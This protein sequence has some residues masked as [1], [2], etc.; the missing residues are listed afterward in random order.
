MIS[1]LPAA[2]R[3]VIHHTSDTAEMVAMG[4]RNDH[5]HDR[6]F[7][8][9]LI[10]EVERGPRRFFDGQRVNHD[11]AGIALDERD[12]REVEAAHLV[13]ARDDLKQSRTPC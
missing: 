10:D 8:E 7:A 2:K 12:V 5:R 9:L 3:S 11:P 4:V 13:D 6:A 1:T